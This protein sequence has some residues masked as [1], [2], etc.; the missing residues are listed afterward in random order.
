MLHQH[1][2][3]MMLRYMHA[4]SRNASKHVIFDPL[5]KQRLQSN[6]VM[7]IVIFMMTF[8][9]LWW[10]NAAWPYFLTLFSAFVTMVSWDASTN[11]T[12][13]PFDTLSNYFFFINIQRFQ[14]RCRHDTA[15]G[16]SLD[17]PLEYIYLGSSSPFFHLG[18]EGKRKNGA[19]FSA[20]RRL[21]AT[22]PWFTI[23]TGKMS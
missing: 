9:Y 11:T 19:L 7:S 10:I 23:L 15:R 2:L 1:F 22:P 13:K 21:G 3:M 4:G 18:R 20:S 5:L 8:H 14:V 17:T 16:L 12:T 6:V